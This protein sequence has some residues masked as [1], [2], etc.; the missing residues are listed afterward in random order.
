MKK[1]EAQ[2]AKERARQWRD[3]RYG[4]AVPATKSPNGITASTSSRRS[5]RRSSPEPVPADDVE[6]TGAE[7]PTPKTEK[8][9]KTMKSVVGQ[10]HKT[11]SRESRAEAVAAARAR[12]RQWSIDQKKSKDPNS[13]AKSVGVPEVV[14]TETAE[15]DGIDTLSD[16]KTANEPTAKEA[17][18]GIILPKELMRAMKILEIDVGSARNRIQHIIC[19]DREMAIVKRESIEGSSANSSFGVMFPAD[20]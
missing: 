6:E 9:K 2:A 18:D 3:E 12:A 4:I 5:I 17:N 11:P 1:A 16:F 13:A 15:E 20:Q 10:Y 19:E 7:N 8:K 14:E